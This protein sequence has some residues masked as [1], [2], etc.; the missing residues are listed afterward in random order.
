MKFSRNR[1]K[2]A[3]AKY[4]PKKTRMLFVA[5][6]P[7]LGSDRYFYF[8]DVKRAD[9]LWIALMKEL[10][11]GEKWGPTKCERRRKRD[12]L[13][14]FQEKGHR[15]IDAVNTP[16]KRGS[17]PA[18]VIKAR[19]RIL[20]SEVKRIN[21]ECVVLIKFSVYDNLFHEFKSAG[22]PVMDCRLPFPGSGHQKEFH[23]KF[24][25]KC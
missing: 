18:K 23:K 15:L 2:Q 13:L 7:P 3:A 21:P 14:K 16:I 17:D 24:P 4:R 11:P 9:W 19:S 12:W 5:E 10:F 1:Y 25:R 22:L 6:A 20:I 8:E